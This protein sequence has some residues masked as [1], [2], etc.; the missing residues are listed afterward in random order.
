M[1]DEQVEVRRATILSL[2]RLEKNNPAVEPE[3][4][5]F[6][7]DPDQVSRVNAVIALA[8]MGKAD[9]S[10]IPVLLEAL[11]SKEKPTAKAAGR[12]LGRMGKN[13]PEMILPSMIQ[14]LEKKEEPLTGYAVQVLRNMKTAAE[15]ALPQIAALYDSADPSTRLDIIDA[16]AAIDK[17][18]GHAIPVLIKGLKAADPLDRKE[19]LLGLMRYREKP[20]PFLDPL[21]ESLKDTDGENRLLAAEIIKGLGNK[22]L[23]AVPQV[24]V[25]FQDPVP[26]VRLTAIG[27][28]GALKPPP[29]E[30]LPELERALKHE[31]PQTRIVA[32]A[33][34]AQFGAAYPN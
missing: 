21:A 15:P 30:A 18:G 22:A 6:A 3:L 32:A 11:G 10:A 1:A 29:R 2:G 14:A 26:R 19:A 27:A 16:V 25:L 4:R 9:D 20:E 31:H 17:D 8:E 12:V 28:V 5:K 34:L 33:A 24:T 7:Q 23:K 13:K